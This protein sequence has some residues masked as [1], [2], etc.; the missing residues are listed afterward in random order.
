VADLPSAQT[1]KRQAV[2]CLVTLDA[3]SVPSLCN[4]LR[5][6]VLQVTFSL[7]ELLNH[8]EIV[9]LHSWIFDSY[10]IG[11]KQILRSLISGYLF[12]LENQRAALA[13]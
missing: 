3:V 7:I 11:F 5:I 9:Y 6:F 1:D 10:V 13:I 12:Y 8:P 2:S 4:I